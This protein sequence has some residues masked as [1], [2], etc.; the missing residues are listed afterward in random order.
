MDEITVLDGE[1]TYTVQV[2]RVRR[3]AV[4]LGGDGELYSEGGTIGHADARA[5]WSV[6]RDGATTIEALDDEGNVS[7]RATVTRLGV[8]TIEKVGRFVFDR[9]RSAVARALRA[10]GGD[11]DATWEIRTDPDPVVEAGWAAQ[12]R[13]YL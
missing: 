5:K 2:E 11:A 6:A 12:R 1:V 7:L 9:Q 4:V 10:I 8:T 3:L 13:A